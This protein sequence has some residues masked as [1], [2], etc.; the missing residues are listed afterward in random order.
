MISFLTISV[1]TWTA[2]TW[3]DS[4]HCSLLSPPAF[5]ECDQKLEEAALRSKFVQQLVLS[6]IFTSDW[7]FS[8]YA[9]LGSATIVEFRSCATSVSQRCWQAWR[10][11]VSIISLKYKTSS[12]LE[13][14]F[15][16]QTMWTVLKHE[17]DL[18]R[19]KRNGDHGLLW[20]PYTQKGPGR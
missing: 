8:A 7:L 15:G 17:A 2:V 13:N 10:G 19:I 3:C 14:V 20:S 9:Q 5:Q 18:Q 6:T 1:G 11:F 12:H 16:N 4:F